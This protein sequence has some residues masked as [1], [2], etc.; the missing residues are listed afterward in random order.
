MPQR[1]AYFPTMA[2]GG[3]AAAIRIALEAL[4]GVKSVNAT[5]ADKLA[6][7]EWEGELTWDAILAHLRDIG[8]PPAEA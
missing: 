8:H 4:P 7:I 6:T 5:V 3:C 1:T 2:C